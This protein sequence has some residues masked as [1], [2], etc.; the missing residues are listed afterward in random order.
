ML[1]AFQLVIVTVLPILGSANLACLEPDFCNCLQGC[2]AI[3]PFGNDQIKLV[4][5]HINTG[6]YL[7]C[8]FRLLVLPN[9]KLFW[10]QKTIKGQITWA[11]EK[12]TFENA[13]DYSASETW[14]AHVIGAKTFGVKSMQSLLGIQ[15]SLFKMTY[16]A[17]LQQRLLAA[18]EKDKCDIAKCMVY[19]AKECKSQCEGLDSTDES[20]LAEISWTKDMCDVEKSKTMV[21]DQC[22]GIKDSLASCDANCDGANSPASKIMFYLLAIAGFTRILMQ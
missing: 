3:D 21:G 22:K 5:K 15:W 20:F 9:L 19:C 18:P 6:I 2:S 1:S 14:K 7:P 10:D 11:K 12:L 4:G 17:N 13:K 16:G 8:D